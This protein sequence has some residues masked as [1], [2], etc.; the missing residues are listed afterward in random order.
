MEI[1]ALTYSN[2]KPYRALHFDNAGTTG[3]GCAARVYVLCASTG[4]PG[5][6]HVICTTECRTHQYPFTTGIFY[7]PALHLFAPL[8]SNCT[9]RSSSRSIAISLA[10]FQPP[11]TPF[12]SFKL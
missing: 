1:K 10:C 4:F 12:S 9:T 8:P 3:M 11:P 6:C 5:L 7:Q 2:D